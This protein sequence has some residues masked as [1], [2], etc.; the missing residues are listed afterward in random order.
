MKCFRH[1]SK[2]YNSRFKNVQVTERRIKKLTSFTD[3]EKASISRDMDLQNFNSAL[4]LVKR[5]WFQSKPTRCGHKRPRQVVPFTVGTSALV[6]ELI[7]TRAHVRI[8]AL[9]SYCM[10]LCMILCVILCMI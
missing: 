3:R 10:M 6:E 5:L 8:S 2:C 1:F 7:F 9:K 4:Q